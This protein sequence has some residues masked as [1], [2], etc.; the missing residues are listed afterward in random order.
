MLEADLVRLSLG[1][2]FL[3]GLW[4]LARLRKRTAGRLLM[5]I[6]FLHLLGGAWVGRGPL[7]RIVR[8]GFFGEAD[9]ALGHVASQMEKELVLW[10]IP[11][12]SP[13]MIPLVYCHIKSFQRAA[14]VGKPWPGGEN[15]MDGW[16]AHPVAW[17]GDRVVA[18]PCA[19][20]GR[21]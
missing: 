2:L 8:E 19:P 13:L 5:L 9:S 14:S 3:M 4:V 16:A 17:G 10:F 11:T 15:W 12:V 7:E 1:L 6:G 21:P 18:F 20:P